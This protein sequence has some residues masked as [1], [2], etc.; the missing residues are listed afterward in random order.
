MSNNHKISNG[1]ESIDLAPDSTIL[2]VELVGCIIPL[3]K[4]AKSLIV[5]VEL[6]LTGVT[7]ATD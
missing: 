6:R 1:S 4:A 5:G 2:T 7:I 3:L